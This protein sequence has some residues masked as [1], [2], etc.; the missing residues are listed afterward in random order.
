MK[1]LFLFILL[2]LSAF[3]IPLLVIY[4][5]L[6]YISK[7]HIL[8]LQYKF[9]GFLTLSNISFTIDHKYFFLS[10]HLDYFQIY[11]IWLKCRIKIKGLKLACNLK[12]SK[13]LVNNNKDNKTN[14]NGFY[15]AF[16]I[17]KKSDL[18]RQEFLKE[19]KEKFYS[20]IKEKYYNKNNKNNI[21]CPTIG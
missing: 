20:I 5:L 7:Y 21:I 9:S 16:D 12:E 15:D 11:L 10:F 2:I 1:L 13:E 18:K 4:L 3:I 14:V 19:I 6:L 8:T 17:K